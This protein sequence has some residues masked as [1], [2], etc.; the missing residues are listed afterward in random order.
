MSLLYDHFLGKTFQINFNW[1][2]GFNSKKDDHY[3]SDLK[4]ISGEWDMGNY[5][6]K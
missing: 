1:F 3:H 6:M 5:M 4:I 2:I